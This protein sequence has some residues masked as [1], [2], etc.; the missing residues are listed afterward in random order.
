MSLVSTPSRPGGASES[1][2]LGS[3]HGDPRGDHQDSRGAKA[4][5]VREE[6]LARA[7]KV[8]KEAGKIRR[9]PG[10]EQLSRQA[11]YFE[12]FGKG[13][14]ASCGSAQAEQVDGRVILDQEEGELEEDVSSE[15]EARQTIRPG[16]T[17]SSALRDDAGPFQALARHGL[18][19]GFQSEQSQGRRCQTSS[20]YMA[21]L[22]A[23]GSGSPPPHR[24]APPTSAST[25]QPVQGHQE[26]PQDLQSP[27][28]PFR[29]DPNGPNMRRLPAEM[30]IHHHQPGPSAL[31]P[32]P[33][34]ENV[35]PGALEAL[36]QEEPAQDASEPATDEVDLNIS[37]DLTSQS[38]GREPMTPTRDEDGDEATP[39]HS[40]RTL[41]LL[42]EISR[43]EENFAREMGYNPTPAIPSLVGHPD[44]RRRLEANRMGRGTASPQDVLG[45]AMAATGISA[46]DRAAAG[47][48]TINNESFTINHHPVVHHFEYSPVHSLLQ[49]TLP[50]GWRGV[51]TSAKRHQRL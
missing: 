31:A 7:D 11:E 44:L 26:D 17:P 19:H 16:T 23:R 6:R 21:M 47:P 15:D 8:R 14:A 9:S 33:G 5:E 51:A 28:G 35:Q 36:A 43:A 40:P 3:D 38:P 30:L 45:Q 42:E 13:G 22:Q 37:G 27:E 41:Q 24:R 2:D 10:K 29:R 20:G 18:V 1:S 25:P 12:G 4:Q 48:S 46:Q 49:S 34:F 39:H 32:P 50:S